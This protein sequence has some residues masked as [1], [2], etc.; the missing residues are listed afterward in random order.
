VLLIR[1]GQEAESAPVFIVTLPVFAPVIL[2]SYRSIPNPGA[3]KAG[4]AVQVHRAVTGGIVVTPI[5]IPV[6]ASTTES[7]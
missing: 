6:L 3:L 4:V 5:G 7:A 2:K 1:C